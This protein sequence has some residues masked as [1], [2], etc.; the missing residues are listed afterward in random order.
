MQTCQL[1]FTVRST[2]AATPLSCQVL[3]DGHEIFS[4]SVGSDI[5]KISHEFNDDIEQQHCVE[6]ILTGKKPEHTVLDQQGHIINDVLLHVD[7]ISLD[8]V[9]L[10][11]V[12]Y[13]NCCYQHNNNGTAEIHDHPFWG[14][15]GCNGVVKFKFFTPAYLWLLENM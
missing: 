10:E 4:G 3:F 15:M 1:D 8:G 13:K 14:D 6:I 2:D 5:T 12:F 7:D 11:H 9:R